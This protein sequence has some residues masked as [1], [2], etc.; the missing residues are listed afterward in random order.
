MSE[1]GVNNIKRELLEHYLRATGWEERK[2]RR[3]ET[4]AGSPQ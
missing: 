4:E 3:A 2:R 1:I